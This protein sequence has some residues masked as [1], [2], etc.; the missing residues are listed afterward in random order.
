MRGSL[1]V[2]SLILLFTTLTEGSAFHHS[3]GKQLRNSHIP[4]ASRK[5]NSKTQTG[6]FKYIKE[7]L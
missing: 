3:A 2:V 6:G 1:C 7:D 5:T 4:P